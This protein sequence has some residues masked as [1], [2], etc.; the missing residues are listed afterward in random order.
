MGWRSA[1]FSCK[2]MSWFQL[3]D[4]GTAEI[5]AHLLLCVLKFLPTTSRCP[6]KRMK[7]E[8]WRRRERYLLSALIGFSDFAGVGY[9]I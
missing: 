9:A 4:F 1:A 3:E 6:K 2:S 8:G 7:T 5:L